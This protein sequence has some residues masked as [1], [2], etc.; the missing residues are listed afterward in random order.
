MDA[1]GSCFV[2]PSTDK[3]RAAAAATK[4]NLLND[5]YNL[6]QTRLLVNHAPI[7]RPPLLYSGYLYNILHNS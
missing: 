1:T 4:L 7:K 6:L 2:R 3:E 5:T